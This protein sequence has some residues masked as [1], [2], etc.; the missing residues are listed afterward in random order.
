VPTLLINRTIA[1]PIAA[2][3]KGLREQFSQFNWLVGEEDTGAP[4]QLVGLDRP[5]TIMGR[6]REGI[7][8]IS[9]EQRHSSHEPANGHAPPRHASH[10]AIGR[11]STEDDDLA[12]LVILI[13]G[14]AIAGSQDE[15][16]RLQLEPGGNWLD[17]G[18]MRALLGRVTDDPGLSQRGL[19]GT[20]E[21]FGADQAEPAPGPP[22]AAP[23][24]DEA[25]GLPPAE[26]GTGLASFSI[27]L[28]GD[29]SIEPPPVRRAGGFGRK[30]L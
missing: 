20:A 24:A 4:D 13:I 9:V 2:I 7:I 11:P 29:V 8:L 27:L 12:R 19:L 21:D 3:R 16:A 25:A 23:A 5:Q 15:D 6:G 26:A 18:D 1:L 17:K 30:G 28:D 10:L 22:V 14:A